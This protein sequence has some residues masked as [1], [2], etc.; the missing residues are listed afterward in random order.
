MNNKITLQEIADKAGLSI[1]VVH[2]VFN[3]TPP[4]GR[5]ARRLIEVFGLDSDLVLFG[6]PFQIKEAIN[7]SIVS[8]KIK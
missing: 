1:G 8:E 3:G 6:T 5:V 2:N 7:K 4:G